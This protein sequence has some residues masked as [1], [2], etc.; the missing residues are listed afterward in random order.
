M[1]P[2]PFCSG[3]G[4]IWRDA[5]IV[6]YDCG[7]LTKRG[8]S[9]LKS[10]VNGWDSGRVMHIQDALLPKYTKW[11]EEKRPRGW[12]MI[13]N[14]KKRIVGGANLSPYESL[15]KWLVYV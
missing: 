3:E 13:E 14:L 10:A 12:E 11:G 7:A 8:H 9:S 2:C 5:F 4:H 15:V 1:K 6:C